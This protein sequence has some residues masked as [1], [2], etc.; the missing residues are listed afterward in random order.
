[1]NKCGYIF[2]VLSL[3]VALVSSVDARPWVNTEG[4]TMEADFVKVEGSL[5]HLKKRNKVYKLE[6]TSLSQKDQ[7]YISEL[8]E[9]LK[10]C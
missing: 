5:V 6:I 9:Q 4:K 2:S 10:L 8:Q 7:D 1:M 3:S